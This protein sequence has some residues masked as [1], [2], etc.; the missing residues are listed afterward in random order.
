MLT[1]FD[2]VSS[3]LTVLYVKV[4]TTRIHKPQ[5]THPPRMKKDKILIHHHLIIIIIGSLI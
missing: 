1:I 2:L 3:L 4:R 5:P